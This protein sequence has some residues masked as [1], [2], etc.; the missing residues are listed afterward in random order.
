MDILKSLDLIL[1][2]DKTMIINFHL[3]WRVTCHLPKKEENYLSISEIKLQTISKRL[4]MS[5]HSI[6]AFMVHCISA[7][8]LQ[9]VQKQHVLKK[10]FK[11]QD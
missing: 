1:L 7:V 2:E 11:M 6:P 5:R 3:R 8:A 9:R 10:F 4:P